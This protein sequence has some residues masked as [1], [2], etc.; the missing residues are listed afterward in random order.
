MIVDRPFPSPVYRGRFVLPV[1]R[2]LETPDGRFDGVV[3]SVVQPN[4]FADFFRTIETETARVISVFHPSGVVLFREP[5]T[6]NPLGEAA[7]EH[8]VVRAAQ[9]AP[10]GGIVKGPLTAGGAPHITAYRTLAVPSLIVAVSLNEHALLADWRAQ[11]RT[12][13]IGFTIF[14]LTSFGLLLVL[15]RQ[16][17]ARTRV[18]QALVEV[19]RVEAD[20]LRQANEQL[21]GA[22]ERE[23]VARELAE[24]ASRLKDE[25]LMTLSH[26]LRTPLNAIVGWVRMLIRGA[27][28]ESERVR[29]LTTI[30]R[31][32]KTQTRLVEDLLDVSRAI[33][34]KLYLRAERVS[35]GEI[36][37]SAVE[38]LRP[39]LAAKGITLEVKVAP[40]LP[41]ILAD[42]DRIQQIIWNL[43]SNAMKFTPS[44]GAIGLHVTPIDGAVE[45]AVEDNG[46]GIPPAFLPYVFDRFRQADGGTRR[47]TGGLGLGLAITRHLV[48]LHG[49]TI[50][51]ESEGSGR[52]AV[53]RVQL[54]AR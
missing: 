33:S 40:G 12:A 32:A 37:L 20:R 42:P 34:G 31:N 2:R 54:P 7:A 28:D 10:A 38:T 11:R 9:R 29:V 30:E 15:V 1:G 18:E 23:K 21:Q 39:A 48:E 36:V 49:G 4:A 27:V 25:F 24:E 50:T 19:Q 8:P 26:E 17:D 45:I 16:I 22:L 51:A 44:A 46:T 52:G 3:V 35:L 13:A 5:S 6:S 14:A 43:L 41:S 47:E 53:F